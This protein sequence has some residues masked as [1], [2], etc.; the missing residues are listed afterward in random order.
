MFRNYIFAALVVILTGAFAPE[1]GE[2]KKPSDYL[3]DRQL[4]EHRTISY[5][6]TISHGNE[7]PMKMEYYRDKDK[8]CFVVKNKENGAFK[9][10]MK[11]I[12][13]QGVVYMVIPEQKMAMKMGANSPMAQSHFTQ[14]SIFEKM[15]PEWLR[16]LKNSAGNKDMAIEEEG[17]E[18]I[19][20]MDCRKIRITNKKDGSESLCYV[21]KDNI[22]RRW[23]F[24]E[25]SPEK[26][27]I[28]YDV[29]EV[30]LDKPVPADKFE[31]PQGYRIT[32]M[33]GMMQGYPR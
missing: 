23:V 10:Q 16:W 29:L 30:S 33:S 14:R 17:T 24:S 12:Y 20:G 32:D 2:C 11:M 7:Q 3:K 9:T 19:R 21:S 26:T 1:T 31:V 28:V 25:A 18:K 6:F 8:E 5:I 22:I 4:K 15:Q 13:G 27:K